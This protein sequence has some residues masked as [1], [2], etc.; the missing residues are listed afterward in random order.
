MRIDHMG[1]TRAR[2]EESGAAGNDTQMPV[3]IPKAASPPVLPPSTGTGNFGKELL[4]AKAYFV[5]D[6]WFKDIDIVLFSHV[7]D[8]LGV[9]WGSGR[10]TGAISVEYTFTGS[11]AHSAIR[12]WKGRSALDAVEL[13]NMGWNLRREHLHPLQR[14]H[15]VIVNGGDQPNVVPKTATVW[16]FIR[17]MTGP[18]IKQNFAKLSRTAAGA[19]LMTD[20]ETSHRI[21]GSAWP[22]NFNRIVAETAYDNIKKVGLP[23]WDKDDQ[24]LATAV[25]KLV[26]AKEIGL[27]DEVLHIL[28][29]PAR[30]ESGGSD[31]IGDISW[32]VPTATILFPSNIRGA[33]SHHWSSAIAMATPIAHKGATAGAKVMAMTA[34]D[35]YLQP[36]KVEQAWQYFRNVQLGDTEYQPFISPQDQPAIEKNRGIMN[37]FKPQLEQYYYQPEK[38]P[39][40]LQQL[41]ISYPTLEKKD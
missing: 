33:L 23:K 26:G 39:S 29:P 5:R 9:S 40:Y 12:P 17:E 11:S 32:N 19:A 1:S 37:K 3:R 2:N 4:G 20:T 22:M 7:F 36:Q 34:L 31:D 24:A 38:Y 8:N 13:M 27:P 14:S 15:H 21:I 25:Q 41:G 6:G 28:G 35:F 30:L 16:Y 18:R 10:G